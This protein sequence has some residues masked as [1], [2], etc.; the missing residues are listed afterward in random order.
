[1]S[2][3]IF[4]L[5]V[6]LLISIGYFIS[7]INKY[8]KGKSSKYTMINI[9]IYSLC[10]IIICLLTLLKIVSTEYCMYG[11]ILLNLISNFIEYKIIKKITP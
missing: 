9:S 8:Q 6:M 3:N 11:I 10:L 2:S 1:M 7:Q 4:L 5:I